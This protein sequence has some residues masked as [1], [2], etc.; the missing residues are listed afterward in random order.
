MIDEVDKDKSGAI[1]KEE[2]LQLMALQ[3]KGNSA[4]EDENQEAFRVF[5][6]D[7]NGMVSKEELRHV[8]T[9][10]GEQLTDDEIDELMNTGDVDQDGFISFDDF[11]QMLNMKSD[12]SESNQL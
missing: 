12:Y 3:I 8:M 5:D 2:F 1:D 7:G 4:E 11:K 6:Q 10:L 9:Y